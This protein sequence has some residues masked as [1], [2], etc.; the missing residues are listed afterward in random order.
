MPVRTNLQLSCRKAISYEYVDSSEARFGLFSLAHPPPSP[1]LAHFNVARY[2]I[3]PPVK[4]QNKLRVYL[5][6]AH[7]LWEN[8]HLSTGTQYMPL[9]SELLTSRPLCCLWKQPRKLSIGMS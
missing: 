4:T 5:P 3:P 7:F 9:N 8:L 1:L 2:V 6:Q